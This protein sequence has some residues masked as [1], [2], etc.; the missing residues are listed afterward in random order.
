MSCVS[1]QRYTDKSKE[2]PV[3]SVIKEE[4]PE[5]QTS[6]LS[7]QQELETDTSDLAPA[8]ST[9][10]QGLLWNSEMSKRFGCAQCGKS[11]R[12]FSQLEIHQR[13]HT[14][15]KPFRCTLC[16]KRYIF[17]YLSSL[18]VHIRRHSGEKPFS[19]P[20]CGKRFAQKTYLK[21]HQRVHSGEKPY[22]CQQCGKSFSQ[23]IVYKEILQCFA[24]RVSE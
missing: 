20:V 15:E 19:C 16:G 1:S 22:S 21:L 6:E 14:G 5:E 8:K 9:R 13:S 23:K 12:C 4:P 18:K 11:F 7:T 10:I 17:N 3:I 2:Q 24:T